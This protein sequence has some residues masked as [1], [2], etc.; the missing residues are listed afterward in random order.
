MRHL[1]GSILKGFGIRNM[2]EADS[3]IDAL[4]V[5]KDFDIDIA[6]V[7][8][9]LNDISGSELIRMIRNDPDGKHTMLP[10]VA[11]TA[12][13]RKPVIYELINAGTDEILSK[14]VAPQ[15]VWQRLVA[16]TERR[17][18]FVRTRDYFGPDRRRAN[19]PRYKGPE[20]RDQVFL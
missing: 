17:R 6:I 18:Q 3:A 14:P 5:L 12:D 16:V 19:D 7:D 4:G 20:R 8:L 1:W 15:A 11:C 10:M 9:V 2:I 13:T